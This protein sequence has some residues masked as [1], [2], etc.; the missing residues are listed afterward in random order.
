MNKSILL[1][2]SSGV[3]PRGGGGGLLYEMPGC[4]CWESENVPIMKDAL[5]KKQKTYRTDPQHAL[6]P[7]YGVILSANV[8]FI[9]VIDN[10]SLLI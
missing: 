2:S 8:S 3:T 4:V 7:Y 10:T 6:Y 1:Y 5:G 9:K